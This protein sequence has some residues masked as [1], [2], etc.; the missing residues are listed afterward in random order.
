M[1]E[2]ELQILISMR[3][4][5]SK[6][7]TG[8]E[9]SLKKTSDS[10]VT[11]TGKMTT[12]FINAQVALGLLEQGGK[13]VIAFFKE[14][15]TASMEA[16]REMQQVAT[17]IN[18]AGFAY[19]KLA[20]K[21]KLAGERAI[22]MGFDD[23]E[24]AQSISKLL[25]ITKDYSQA[26]A[27]NNLAMDLSRNKGV[28]LTEATS[29]LAMVLQG[30]GARA[31]VQYGL[32]FKDGSTSAE[33]LIQLQEKLKN[34]TTGFAS[35]SSGQLAVLQVQ[36]K[37]IKEE[38]GDKLMP[39]VIEFF[40]IIENNQDTITALAKG[41]ADVGLAG[42]WVAKQFVASGKAIAYQIGQAKLSVMEATNKSVLGTVLGNVGIAGWSPFKNVGKKEDTEAIKQ[43]KLVVDE[44]AKSLVELEDG[45]GNAS[46]PKKTIEDIKKQMEK[47]QKAL[48]DIVN[49]STKTTEAQTA[50]E[51][52]KKS[53]EDASDAYGD[54][55][56]TVSSTLIDLK[57]EHMDAVTSMQKDIDR[58]NA[59]LKDLAKTYRTDLAGAMDTYTN[60]SKDNTKSVAGAIV[61]NEEAIATL[62]ANISGGKMNKDDRRLAE[63]ELATRLQAEIDNA[64][65]ITSLADEIKAIKDYNALSELNQA[66]AD[67]NTK[68]A[69]AQQEYS[70]N[71]AR[72]TAEYN[73]KKL[74][75]R[76]ELNDI[77]DK[78]DA[79]EVLYD[80][81]VKYINDAQALGFSVN[82]EYALANL[83]VTAEQVK[84]EI[85]YYAELAKAISNARSGNATKFSLIKDDISGIAIPKTTSVKDVIIT[86]QGN[87][88][89]HPDDYIIA[90]KTPGN[91]GKGA[92]TININTMIG[93]REF[94]EEM[95]NKIIKQLQLQGQLS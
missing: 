95:G 62:Q 49:K 60:A 68:Q 14:S 41:L 78:Q 92:I 61:A 35:T 7:L 85:A 73:T 45:T 39:K 91:L 53:V 81:K 71:V 42:A 43:Q 65:L 67:F 64:T 46:V 11:S 31:L 58:V 57:A 37:N 63:A 5:F 56:K 23:E 76:N 21:I 77:R 50:L 16:S 93:N 17:N 90:T 3:D 83:K 59:S 32:S 38:V 19:D 54:L 72:I 30:Q 29:S 20:P 70:A 87:Y 94:A 28:S 13:M 10:A 1:K 33:I 74:A 15:I 27:L 8:I 12:A 66:V 55:D 40:A 6:K 4:E 25:L 75:L 89:T 34:S 36:W 79:E 26:I 2:R 51:D 9:S 18:N 44:L 47:E 69:L 48:A 86:P 52:L 88:S 82:K 84:A 80:S 22:Q 24:S